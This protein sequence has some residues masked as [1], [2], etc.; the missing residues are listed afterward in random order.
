VAGVALYNPAG[1]SVVSKVVDMQAASAP[2][3]TGGFTI[4]AGT[5][6]LGWASFDSFW[7][8]GANG[9]TRKRFKIDGRA[10][11]VNTGQVEPKIFGADN[12]LLED[13]EVKYLGSASSA[14]N[15][16]AGKGSDITHVEGIYLGK[17]TNGTLRYG[18]FAFN[19]GTTCNGIFF[20][21]FPGTAAQAHDIT[22][23]KCR[24]DMAGYNGDNR[25][26]W[27]ASILNTLNAYPIQRINFVDCQV[28][29][30]AP[31]IGGLGTGSFNQTWGTTGTWTYGGSTTGGSGKGFLI[32]PAGQPFPPF[33]DGT[34]CAPNVYA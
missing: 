17:A 22:V 20:T 32:V 8:N 7:C 33:P 23:S 10:H 16:A 25:T 9:W 12:F 13:F 31:G 27:G 3:P 2:P 6:D 28:R 34:D 26:H 18:Y 15:Q 24:F 4:T 5:V 30:G 29:A 11:P 1:V 21:G 14:E 19:E